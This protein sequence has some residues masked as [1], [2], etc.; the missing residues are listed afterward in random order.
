M[1]EDKENTQ[2]T[3]IIESK[4]QSDS[5][6]KMAS[7]SK[8]GGR[9]AVFQQKY[10]IDLDAELAQYSTESVKAYATGISKSDTLDFIT[11]I[12]DPRYTP[13]TNV[14]KYYKQLAN[15][16]LPGLIANGRTR[17][18]DGTARYCYIYKNNMGERIYEADEN[19]A[20]GWKMEKVLETIII[21]I[22]LSLKELQQRDVTHG[23]IRAT[24][25][26]DGGQENYERV[27]LGEC[28]STPASFSQPAIYEPIQRAMAD[29]IGRG[30][31]TIK[32]DLYALGVLIAMHIRNFD[33]LRGKDPDEI[34]AAKVVTGSYAALIGSSDRIPSGIS[35]LVRGLLTD[36]E[37]NRWGLDDVME[38]LDGRRHSTKQSFKIK[39]AA[40]AISFM[41]KNFL[42]ARTFAYRMSQYP[43]EA[44]P[45]VEGNELRHWIERSLSDKE[46]L[47][48]VEDAYKAAQEGD[49]GV[50]YWDR[51]MPRISIAMD[52]EAP[53]R[54]KDMALHPNAIG[55]TLACAFIEKRDLK[56][57]TDLFNDGLLPFWITIQAELNIDVAEY[58]QIFD[59]VRGFLKQ[60]SMMSG[61]ERCLYFLN[62]SIHC[63]SPH[64]EEYYATS[65]GEYLLALERVAEIKAPKFPD[66]IIDKHAACFLLSRDNR[67][68]EPHAYDLSSSDH[69]RQ[70]NATLKILA[71]I[72][73][74]ND[75]GPLPNLTEWVC[76]LLTPVIERYHDA[77]YQQKIKK[78][79]EEKKQNG[80]LQQILQIIDSPDK[81]KKD[82]IAYRRALS[83][84]RE[85]ETEKDT[86]IKKQ[87][88]PK[89]F[90]ERTG[91]EWAA[92]ISGVISVL[93][94]IGFLMVHYGGELPVQ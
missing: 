37:R 88:K 94:I 78:D 90:A 12:C 53:I 1:A 57:Y 72:Q 74:F 31:G 68:I 45:L 56:N 65:L 8:K 83:K 52:Y 25:L 58:A 82:Q 33:P 59:K 39:K 64:V 32:D 19:I 14:T 10:Y 43:Q 55:N 41:G 89:Y 5:S 63:L 50:G 62:P 85:L 17:M 34:I 79:I 23:N 9:Y 46:M 13:R 81:I 6:T 28:L 67:L 4:K 93:I 84:Y 61:V 91:R 7:P 11:F 27:K 3:E 40:R 44:A 42:Y 16:T 24:N 30:E 51:L 20:L 38:W 87:E 69:F 92:T 36:S 47:A 54:Y 75:V 49:L 35:T 29:P 2:D 18:P 15:E 73:K 76:S 86:I 26:Y 77:N 66:K 71:A 70:I 60:D 48:R 22:V 80:N 21:P